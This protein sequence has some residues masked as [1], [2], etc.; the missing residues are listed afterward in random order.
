MLFKSTNLLLISILTLSLF[1]FFNEPNKH[2]TSNQTKP[3]SNDVLQQTAEN[4][5]GQREGAIIVLDTQIG[6]IRAVVNK[7]IAFEKAMS[8]GSTIKPFT[9]LTALREGLITEDSTLV[10]RAPYKRDDFSINCVHGAEE[11]PFDVVHALAHSCNFYF[12]KLGERINQRKFNATLSS[13]GFDENIGKLPKGKWQSKIAIGETE[14][15]LVTPYNLIKAYSALVM[16]EPPALAGG[17]SSKHRALLIEGMRGA[18]EYGTAEKA[19]LDEISLNIFGKTGTASGDG[20]YRMQG[21][22]VGFSANADTKGR[23]PNPSEINLAVLVFIKGAH[24]SDC[25]VASKQ[26]FSAFASTQLAQTTRGEQQITDIRVKIGDEIKTLSLEDY[27]TGVLVTESSFEDEAE[28]LKAQA[29]ASR[30]YAVKHLKRHAKDGYD[31]CTLTHCQRFKFS[32]GERYKR[33]VKETEGQVLLDDKGD[34]AEAYFSSSCG[35]ATANL[36][37]L[38]GVV[39]KSYLKTFRDDYCTEMPHSDWS[40]TITTE[41]MLKALQSD[42]RTNVG[43]HLEQIQIIEKDS[44]GRAQTLRLAGE[45]N[46]KVSGWDFKIIVGRVIGWNLI[47]SSRFAV[48]KQGKKF[49]FVGSGFGHGLGLCQEGAHVMAQRGFNH[50]QILARYYP[51]TTIGKR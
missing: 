5:L 6:R 7:E 8:P 38:W 47:K 41:Q 25:A 51:T 33:A 9:A 28:A 23:V 50:H 30:T 4:A 17:L 42:K 49:V 24:G 20:N 34:F 39:S 37:E 10:C 36:F 16:S 19:N 40:A 29:I 43:K 32:A 18:V 26:I 1:S 3:D 22:F 11:P 48:K 45:R 12:G 21:W 13:F 35:G 2:R 15:L 31:F 46:K 27:L 44:S 14:E